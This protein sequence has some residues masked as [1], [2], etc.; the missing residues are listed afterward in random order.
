MANNAI[1]LEQVGGVTH[2]A[3]HRN[4]SPRGAEP[5]TDALVDGLLPGYRKSVAA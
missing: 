4:G 5:E 2:A 3:I 1:G